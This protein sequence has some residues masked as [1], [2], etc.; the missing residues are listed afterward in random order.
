VVVLP[1]FDFTIDMNV[2]LSSPRAVLKSMSSMAPRLRNFAS[3][4]TRS[5]RRFSRWISSGSTS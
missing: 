1:H 2:A 5:S 3:F 4:K